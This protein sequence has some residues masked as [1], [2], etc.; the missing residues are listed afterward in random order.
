MSAVRCRGYSR[1]KKI[2]K[3]SFICCT[4]GALLLERRRFKVVADHGMY[5]VSFLLFCKN[6]ALPNV[7]IMEYSS[8]P[9]VVK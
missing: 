8:W 2:W 6:S 5:L 7:K 9:Y 3:H 1:A 4:D